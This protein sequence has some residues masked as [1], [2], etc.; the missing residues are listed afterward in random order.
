MIKP[1][2]KYRVTLTE[3][4]NCCGTWSGMGEPLVTV[5]ATHGYSLPW[6]RYQPINSGPAGP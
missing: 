3:N 2:I 6:M 4:G 5:Y 1:N